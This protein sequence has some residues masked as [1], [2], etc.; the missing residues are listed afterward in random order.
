MDLRAEVGG[1]A[2]RDHVRLQASES[3]LRKV[4]EASPD[5]IAVNSLADGRF[6]AVNDEY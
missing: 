6:I 1:C 3:M 2:E 5:N 4:F